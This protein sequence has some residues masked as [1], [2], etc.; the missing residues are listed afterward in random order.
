MG[1]VNGVKICVTLLGKRQLLPVA[2]LLRSKIGRSALLWLSAGPWLILLLSVDA[3]CS[4]AAMLSPIINRFLNKDV[5][6]DLKKNEKLTKMCCVGRSVS[7]GWFAANPPFGLSG[8]HLTVFR[9][10][11][12]FTVPGIFVSAN[13]CISQFLY[14]QGVWNH[15]AIRPFAKSFGSSVLLQGKL[16]NHLWSWPVGLWHMVF[17][18]TPFLSSVAFKSITRHSAF[19]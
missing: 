15:G 19:L 2:A 12:S 5:C 14:L 18:F 6:L 11:F 17:V 4:H 8:K 10:G 7:S 16:G 1:N 9:R 13:C 3:A